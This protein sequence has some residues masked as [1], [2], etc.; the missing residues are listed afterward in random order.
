MR[1]RQRKREFV[2]R[3][4]FGHYIR[5]RSQQRARARSKGAIHP[6]RRHAGS[7][8]PNMRPGLDPPPPRS[9]LSLTTTSHTVHTRFRRTFRWLGLPRLLFMMCAVVDGMRGSAKIDLE[10]VFWIFEGIRNLWSSSAIPCAIFTACPRRILSGT[11]C[12]PCLSHQPR[13]TR[14]RADGRGLQ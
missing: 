10:A 9:A 6:D 1:T 4:S 14:T 5:A 12:R 3:V 7:H 13:R 2:V 11:G 8:S